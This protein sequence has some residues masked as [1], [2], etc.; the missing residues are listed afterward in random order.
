[1]KLKNGIIITEIDGSFYAVDAGLEGK[2]FGGMIKMNKTA[3]EIARALQSETDEE[4]L[5]DMLCE[6]YDVDKDTAMKDVN[7]IIDGFVSA[8]LITY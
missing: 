1:M 2:R 5:A 4:R 8:E 3:E 6:K 7:R